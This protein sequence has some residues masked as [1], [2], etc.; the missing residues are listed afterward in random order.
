MQLNKRLRPKLHMFRRCLMEV[1][2]SFLLGA[3]PVLAHSESAKALKEILDVLL[4]STFFMYYFA[5]LF[6]AFMV[7]ALIQYFWRFGN[8]RHQA[9]L[10]ALHN[11]LGNVGAG[12]LSAMRTGAGAIMGFL[13]VWHSLEPETMT[14]GSVARTVFMVVILIYISAVLA[15]GE[16]A[17][18]D[19]RGT[20]AK[21]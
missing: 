16:E 11:I 2:I 20:S 17:L 12:F 13:I 15:L 19:P 14:L 9:G 3:V 6:L 18:R 21:R 8:E 1:V 7:A 5:A 4:A 10:L